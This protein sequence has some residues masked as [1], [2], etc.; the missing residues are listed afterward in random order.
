MSRVCEHCG[1]DTYKA[2]DYDR[3]SQSN[4]RL[5]TAAERLAAENG[6]LRHQM[7]LLEMDW[8]DRLA[9][10]QRKIQR[11]RAH[12]RRLANRLPVQER[13]YAGVTADE[14]PGPEKPPEIAS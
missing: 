10:F 8:R 6:V 5:R 11:Q 12:I 7:A 1:S 13:P 9:R 4:Q 2:A 14:T 3:Q